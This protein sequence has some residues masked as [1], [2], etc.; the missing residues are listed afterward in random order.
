VEY[1]DSVDLSVFTPF[2]STCDIPSSVAD[3]H[4]F[5]AAPAPGK[6]FDAAPAAPAPTLQYC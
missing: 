4:H 2:V 5:Y 6:N 1:E 3:P